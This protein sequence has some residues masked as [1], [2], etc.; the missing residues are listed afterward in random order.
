MVKPDFPALFAPGI[1]RIT[2]QDFHARAVAPFAQD[3]RRQDL[4]QQF[5]TWVGALQA[6]RVTGKLWLDGSFLTEK[7]SPNDIDCVIWSPRWTVAEADVTE[8]MRQRATHLLNQ[9]VAKS[10]YG[11]D[12]YL[13]A[14]VP[15][16]EI[17]RE[18]YWR[19]FFGFSHDR[20]TAKGIA[21]VII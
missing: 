2:I 8:A 19:G 20:V 4:H 15:D 12:L 10:V 1:H 18:A 3:Q 11:L 21:E 14:P 17:H 5:T 7:P 16:H 13:E 6:N 9:Q